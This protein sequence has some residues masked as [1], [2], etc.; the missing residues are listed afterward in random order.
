MQ[1]ADFINCEQ[2]A[3]LKS[4]IVWIH[5]NLPGQEPDAPDLDVK[6]YPSLEELGEEMV[7]VLNHYSIPHVVCMGQGAGANIAVHFSVKHAAKCLG[8]ILIEPV[9]SSASLFQS[10]KFKLMQRRR[11]I[12]TNSN[13]TGVIFS[14]PNARLF[15][16]RRTLSFSNE[17]GLAT[18]PVGAKIDEEVRLLFTPLNY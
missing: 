18:S 11:T 6:K 13:E 2:M 17:K 7:C 9:G 15:Q 8:L 10:F 4:R 1:F 16:R 5:V 14:P 3:T 12:S